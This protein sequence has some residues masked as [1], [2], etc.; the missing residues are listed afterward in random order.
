[1]DYNLFIHI[2]EI[3]WGY[4]PLTNHLLTSWDIQVGFFSPNFTSFLHFSSIRRSCKHFSKPS[5]VRCSFRA[6]RLAR[7]N[8][9]GVIQTVG[10]L[11]SQ[12]SLV[13][14]GLWIAGKLT[15]YHI[16]WRQKYSK[17]TQLERIYVENNRWFQ[18]CFFYEDTPNFM[19]MMMQLYFFSIGCLEKQPSH[20]VCAKVVCCI[21]L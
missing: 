16:G 17:Q 14:A 1:M 19:G 21:F 13:N 18:S 8:S 15:Y 12:F 5:F 11:R 3:Y 2:H 9:R 6:T 4:I 7:D 20:F 10:V